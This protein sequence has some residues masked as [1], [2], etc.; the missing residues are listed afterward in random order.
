[1]HEYTLSYDPFAGR[2]SS[3]KVGVDV[4]S[5]LCWAHLMACTAAEL[6]VWS[7]IA[8][9]VPVHCTEYI[10]IPVGTKQSLNVGNK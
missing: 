3:V 8:T 9:E 7:G 10:C 1:M 6:S 4:C 2:T 5:A